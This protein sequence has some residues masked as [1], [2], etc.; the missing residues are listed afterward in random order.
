MIWGGFVGN[1]FG[2]TGYSHCCTVGCRKAFGVDSFVVRMVVLGMT[3]FLG[4]VGP[5]GMV[6]LRK[7]FGLVD[8]VGFVRMVFVVGCCSTDLVLS[9]VIGSFDPVVVVEVGL[10]AAH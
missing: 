9:S 10:G 3:R 8:M 7:T 2:C 4:S 1:S 6:L 5:L